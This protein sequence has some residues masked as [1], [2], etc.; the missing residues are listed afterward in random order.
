MLNHFPNFTQTLQTLHT[1]QRIKWWTLS[2][3][4][5]KNIHSVVTTC[6]VCRVCR[7]GATFDFQTWAS[8]LFSVVSPTCSKPLCP[9]CL[10]FLPQHWSSLQQR[11]LQR[12][13]FCP[14]SIHR[15][16]LNAQ[17]PLRCLPCTLH[18]QAQA[19]WPLTHMGSSS[20]RS[21]CAGGLTPS[22]G[23]VNATA[24]AAA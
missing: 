8:P 24:E 22:S 9:I 5:M 23:G 15:C 10:L 13:P 20:Y 7:V 21:D 6:R 19:T 16:R 3:K 2:I 12:R 11:S 14:I 4:K 1:L 18:D 17:S